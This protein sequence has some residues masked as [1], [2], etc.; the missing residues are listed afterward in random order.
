MGSS[1]LGHLPPLA[2]QAQAPGTHSAGR[3]PKALHPNLGFAADEEF[4]SNSSSISQGCGDTQQ[5]ELLRES[6]AE[7]GEAASELVQGTKG[8]GGVPASPPGSAQTRLFPAGPVWE[9]PPLPALVAALGERREQLLGE[10][11]TS[12]LS[13]HLQLLLITRNLCLLDHTDQK[14]LC[15]HLFTFLAV[16]SILSSSAGSV[17]PLLL[18]GVGLWAQPG[19]SGIPP[20]CWDQTELGGSVW[21][22]TTDPEV[23]QAGR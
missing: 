10:C 3:A 19:T 4:S 17:L 1:F 16:G 13:W 6:I 23:L 5:L 9:H 14:F 11:S 12:S 8:I 7:D 22:H 15:F 18:A 20:H 2:C 21:G